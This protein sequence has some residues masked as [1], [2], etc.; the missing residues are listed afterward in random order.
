MEHGHAGGCYITGR[1]QDALV[2]VLGILAE[3]E[4]LLER[5]AGHVEQV[6]VDA[7]KTAVAGDALELRELAA[8][9]EAN[10]GHAAWLREQNR[11]ITRKMR[12]IAARVPR[13]RKPKRVPEV[14]DGE[15]EHAVVGA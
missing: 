3:E 6:L 5:V 12:R 4:L 11:E 13:E 14:Q 9:L 1:E 2:D 10:R 15:A 8:E 7:G